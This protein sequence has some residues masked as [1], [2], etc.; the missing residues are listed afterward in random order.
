MDTLDVELVDASHSRA[1]GAHRGRVVV[2]ADTGGPLAAF[3]VHVLGQ[4]W[5][6]MRRLHSLLG[7]LAAPLD[8]LLLL[9]VSAR[10]VLACLAVAMPATI[11]VAAVRLGGSNSLGSTV[12][13]V[14]AACLAYPCL[15]A[16][17]VMCQWYVAVCMA[18]GLLHRFMHGSWL[19]T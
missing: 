14:L 8:D 10:G 18:H 7:F 5:D 17:R 11:N 13:G 2:A 15:R 4:W 6:H 1:V 12:L 19:T 16:L 3:T 9:P